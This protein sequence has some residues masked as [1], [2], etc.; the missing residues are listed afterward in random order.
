MIT[1]AG[2][3]E[4]MQLRITAAGNCPLGGGFLFVAVVARGHQI[5]A[6]VPIAALQF[7]QDFVWRHL[8]LSGLSL[9]SV[10]V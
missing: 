7:R 10:S 1:S 4:S 8:V 9:P 3:R 5:L 6:K 2:A